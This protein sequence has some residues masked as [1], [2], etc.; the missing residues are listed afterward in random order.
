MSEEELISYAE[1]VNS[2][3]DSEFAAIVTAFYNL[4]E[5]DIV[6]SLE[7]LNSMPEESFIAALDN[8]QHI[9]FR[10]QY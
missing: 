6:S 9:E 2:F 4:S 5:A 7:T 1:T 3:S 8:I 10:Y